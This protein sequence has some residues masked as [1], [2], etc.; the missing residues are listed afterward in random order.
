MSLLDVLKQNPSF[1]DG[2]EADRRAKADADSQQVNVAK[3]MQQL[4]S[5]KTVR[6]AIHYPSNNPQLDQKPDAHPQFKHYDHSLEIAR[7]WQNG[8]AEPL[9]P[10]HPKARATLGYW[11]ASVSSEGNSTDQ[12]EGEKPAWW[13]ENLEP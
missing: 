8:K 3:A 7:Q 6:D 5:G 9:S 11:G 2:V 1:D 12:V 4:F 10:S 13:P